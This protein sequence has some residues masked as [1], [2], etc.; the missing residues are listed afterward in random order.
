MS[1]YSTIQTSLYGPVG[2]VTLNRPGVHHALNLTMIRELTGALHAL[3]ADDQIRIVLFRSSGANFSAGADINWMREGRHQSREQLKQESMELAGLFRLITE[4]PIPCVCAVQ[5]KVIGGANGLIAASD[6]V[7]AENTAR[8][9]FSE[10]K[11]GLIPATIAPFVI[12]KAGRSRTAAWMLSGEPF[13]TGEA[14]EGG[15]V[16]YTC[17]AGELE[18][19]TG[20]IISRLLK[21]GPEAMKGIK[22]MLREFSIH[23][24]A[25]TIQ[26]ESAELIADTRISSEG[27]EGMNAF[28]EKRKPDWD[29]SQESS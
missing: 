11:L 13:S 25:Q 17:A 20:Q 12:R 7:I 18:K 28:L 21:G 16:H 8:F 3:E 5:G 26:E 22:K 10:V 2:T 29:V 19:K 27:Q 14:L 24:G 6:L 1:N 9:S 23:A 15:L 4:I